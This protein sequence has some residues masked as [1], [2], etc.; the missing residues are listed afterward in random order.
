MRFNSYAFALFFAALLPSYWLLA[1]MA[2]GPKCSA[3]GCGLL[4]LRMLEPQVPLAAHSL[5]SRRL[6]MRSLARSR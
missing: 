6:R 4:F 3:A 2:A 1:Q 5:D